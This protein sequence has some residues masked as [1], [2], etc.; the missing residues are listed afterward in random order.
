KPS[1]V[2]TAV[3]LYMPAKPVQEVPRPVA[4][5]IIAPPRV[6][7]QKIAPKLELPKPAEVTPPPVVAKVEPPPLPTPA[8]PKPMA[9]V[10]TGKFDS[11]PNPAPVARGNPT[12]EI[13]TGVFSGSS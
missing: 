5:K 9:K 1:R 10:E 8:P 2:Y 7:V 12:K 3:E 11:N 13:E 4:Q 6:L